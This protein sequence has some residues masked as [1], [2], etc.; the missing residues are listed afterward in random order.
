MESFEFSVNIETG[1]ERALRAFW[2]L[3]DW[4]S[5]APHVRDI[6][7]HYRDDSVQ[8]LTMRVETRGR[9]D[10]FKSVRFRQGST[11]FYFQPSPPPI[12]RSHNGSWH[13]AAGPGHTVVTSR[14]YVDVDVGA[15]ARLLAA[16]DAAPPDG[17]AVRR[18]VQALIRNNSL[19]TMLA[20]KTR[21]ERANGE[22]HA[23]QEISTVA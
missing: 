15:A 11:I 2:E 21:L 18:Q 12:L 13:F 4:P 22:N 17:E 16:A 23:Q 6:R 5:V 3:E 9:L 7:M 1:P 8:V 10:S 19:Q 20:L 14:H